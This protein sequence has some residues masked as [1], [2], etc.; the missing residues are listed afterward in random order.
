MVFT[1]ASN[2]AWQL[3]AG[4]LTA[5]T[6]QLYENGAGAARITVKE[7]GNVG[8][9]MAPS[10]PLDTL[11]DQN[12]GW[13]ARLGNEGNSTPY[14]LWI[15]FTDAAPNNT[16]QK[17][18]DCVDNASSGTNRFIVWADGTCQNVNG[19]FSAISD[20][21][22]KQ[23][24]TDARSYWDD[25]KALKFRKFRLKS[26]VAADANAPS[27][28]G[29]VAQELETV[30]PS[31]VY[32]SPDTEQQQIAVLDEDGNPTYEQTQKLTDDGDAVLDDD[33]NAVMVDDAEKPITEEKMVDL[34]TTTKSAKYS[35]L[36]QIG[37]KVVQ[38]LQTRLEAAEAKI[39]TLESA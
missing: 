14:G 24:I 1:P 13:A 19:T 37:L 4:P 31:L 18:I 23:D 20:S 3:G 29:V 35:I 32:E 26:D 9:G 25:F 22:L 28:L 8:I 12:G 6:F 27:M 39:A 21:K 5:A 11:G 33:G 7:G 38:E 34:G 2:N 10:Y 30:F 15:R 36:G 16:A 17:F